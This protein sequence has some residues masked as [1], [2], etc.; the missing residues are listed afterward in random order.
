MNH[1]VMIAHAFPPEG[2]A[3]TYRPLRFARQLPSLGWLPTVLS[4]RTDSYHRYDPALV[5]LIPEAVHVIRVRNRDPWKAIQE[6]RRRRLDNAAAAGAPDA[7]AADENAQNSTRSRVREFVRFVEAA[8]YHPDPEMGWIRPATHALLEICR[9]QAP[10]VLWATAGPVSAF[11][12]AER[13]S[14]RTG[15]PYVLDFRDSW[16]ITFNEFEDR[17]PVWAKRLE[18]RRLYRQL[19]G[20]RSIIFR[21]HAEAECFSRAYNGA[22][23]ASQVHIIPNGFEGA[24][25]AFEPPTGDRCEILYTG[26]LGDYRYDS[27]LRALAR[28]Q[29]ESPPVASR[30]HFTF[31]GEQADRLEVE[32]NALG[33]GGLVTTRG[34]VPQEHVAELTRQA[35]ALLILGRP[36]TLRGFELFAAAKLFGYL[37][38]GMPIL[39]VVP[40][41][42]TRHVLLRIGA[43]VAAVDNES[44]IA[45]VISRLVETWSDGAI[46][47]MSPSRSA[48]LAYSAERQTADLVRALEG[49][50]SNDPFVA[51]VTPVPAS[52]RDEI[53]RRTRPLTASRSLVFRDG[54]Q[55]AD[56]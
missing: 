29:R 47:Q 34:P 7:S 3:G 41:D 16:T 33:L 24:I 49:R 50:P 1:V 30:V 28:L 22:V 20:A 21:S 14:S 55:T 11:C 46:A 9:T 2:H 31:V 36:Q 51:G 42:E 48:C 38:T 15:V 18:E 54:A 27:L 17:R 37:R 43:T 8:C 52:L 53:A 56:R 25:Q 13:V 39:G 45:A 10:T 32:T 40:D 23:R 19:A 5:S 44:E 12:V 26:T 4:L 35:H 6:W